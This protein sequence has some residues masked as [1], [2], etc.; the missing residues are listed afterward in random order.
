[1]EYLLGI[2]G[3]GTK[4]EVA[5]S[6][7]EGNIKA[8]KHYKGSSN[9]FISES[10]KDRVVNSVY[11]T[12]R[13]VG[14]PVESIVS[15][16]MSMVGWTYYKP[17]DFPGLTPKYL[18]LVGDAIGALAAA[19]LGNQGIVVM[20]GTGSLGFGM[21][22]SGELYKIGGAGSLIDD[23]GSGYEIAREALSITYKFL[24]KRIPP[25]LVAKYTMSSEFFSF[26]KHFSDAVSAFPDYPDD[27]YREKLCYH[28]AEKVHD[29]TTTRTDIASLFPIVVQADR[30]SDTVAGK[31]LRKAGRDLAQLAIDVYRLMKPV[32]SI[33]VISYA[34][35]IIRSSKTIR[36]VFRQKILK[37]I[38]GIRVIDPEFTPVIGAVLQGAKLYGIDIDGSFLQN[39]RKSFH[40]F[41]K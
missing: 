40:L 22:S 29:G 15:S 16:C 17:E 36:S 9:P 33:E 38:P 41:L 34:G 13:S 39:I 3:G 31:I 20:A 1:M 21:D 30:E 37:E 11:E 19:S 24:Q 5:V 7:I 32:E 12:C 10:A 8:I 35:G 28:L 27:S 25:N 2:D 6:D 4:V 23:S 18:Y 14:I 26:Y